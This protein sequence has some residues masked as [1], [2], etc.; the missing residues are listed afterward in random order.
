MTVRITSIRS[1]SAAGLS[2]AALT[3]LPTHAHA[4][5]A[6][7]EWAQ[8]FSGHILG[9]AGYL[10]NMVGFIGGVCL[11]FASLVMIYLKNSGKGGGHNIGYSA[12]VSTAF[13]GVGLLSITIYA[14][15]LSQTVWGQ[16]GSI[17][18]GQQKIT[19]DQ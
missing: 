16:K 8:S 12:I 10:F 17:T 3:V 6:F 18:G 9:G 7:D 1:L 13:V 14:G 11:L 5:Q 15:V 4:A 2:A 19:F